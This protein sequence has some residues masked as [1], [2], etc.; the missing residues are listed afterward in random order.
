[1]KNKYCSECDRNVQPVKK[2]KK[3]YA[4]LAVVY[5]FVPKKYCPICGCKVRRRK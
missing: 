3:R 5:L 4:L 1:M 2:W